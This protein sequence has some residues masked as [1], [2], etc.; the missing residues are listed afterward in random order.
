MLW[1][2]QVWTTFLAFHENETWNKKGAW[3]ASI[4]LQMDT[5][6]GYRLETLTA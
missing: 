4:T 5:K 2:S 6:E 3:V 1:E